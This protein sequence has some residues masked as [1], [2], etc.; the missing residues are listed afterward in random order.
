MGVLDAHGPRGHLQNAPRCV[1]EL[2]H[3]TRQALDGKVFVQRANEDIA[4]VQHDAI[5]RGVRD[6]AARGDRGEA[7]GTTASHAGIH[8]VAVHQRG[9]PPSPRGEPVAEHAQDAIETL[10]RELAVRVRAPE[11]IQQVALAVSLARGFG[12]DLLRKHVER[13]FA[14]GNPIQLSKPDGTKQCRAFDEIVARGRKQACL[15]NSSHRVARPPRTLEKRRDPSR[16][17]DLTHQID[18]ADVDSQ[19]ERRG[20]DEGLQAAVLESRLGVEPL[21]LREA[22][23]V[24]GHRVLAE[25][26]AEMTCHTLCQ[27][28]CV[29]ENQRR[30]VAAC[31]L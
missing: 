24:R 17:P 27:P 22:A 15:G 12:D 4:R 18:V 10:A 9:P 5:I 20:G 13:T 19:L 11:L 7:C 28:A 16:R 21:L 8:L 31:Q 30:P 26:L 25:A 3:V 14:D 23:M 2:K 29:H 1:A 6:R